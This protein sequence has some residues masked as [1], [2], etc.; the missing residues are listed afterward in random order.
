M[1]TPTL[2]GSP[3]SVPE[4]H[5]PTTLTGGRE[6]DSF[7][8]AAARVNYRVSLITPSGSWKKKRMSDVTS[9]GAT[10]GTTEETRLLDAARAAGWQLDSLSGGR[11]RVCA[12]TPAAKVTLLH[13]ALAEKTPPEEAIRRLCAGA[14]EL[15]LRGSRVNDQGLAIIAAACGII[16]G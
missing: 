8:T 13:G 4:L 14:S 9:V 2:A 15:S 7:W 16:L 1:I 6:F 5:S 12:L 10:I 11:D 3:I